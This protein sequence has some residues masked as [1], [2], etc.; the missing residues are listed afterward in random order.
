MTSP[1]SDWAVEGR[2]AGLA[3]LTVDSGTAQH[4]MLHGGEMRQTYSVFLGELGSGVH[5]LSVERNDVYSAKG[6]GVRVHGA[7]FREVAR[8]DPMWPVVAHAPVL[9]AR[10]NTVGH[11]SDVPL[12]AYCERLVENGRPVLQYTVV[13]SNEDGGT[14]TRALM[15]RWGRATD[16]EYVYR[17]FL[18]DGRA[19]IQARDHKEVE[20]R[21]Q[22]D[23]GH[24]LLI[25]STQNNMVSDEGH[26][27]I[28]YQLAPVLVD[29][30]RQARE[31]VMDNA[32]LAYRV[33]AQE[34][35]REAKLR[36]FGMVDGEKISDPRN[37]LYLEA[38][39]TNRNSAV[40]VLARLEGED[41]WRSSHLGRA[42]YAI[43]RDG[44][45]RT[46]IEL[47]L[48]SR[49]QIAELAFECLAV[50][51]KPQSDSGVCRVE[52][53]SKAFLL[54]GDYTPGESIWSLP[55]AVAIPSGQVR[56]FRLGSRDVS[57]PTAP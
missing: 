18:D 53:V 39:V 22:R 56:A 5:Q 10:A 42:S 30:S 13:F 32:P 41:T 49:E 14:S 25:P 20:F 19:T 38:K 43:S 9:F 57:R 6:S 29:L 2:E 3:T 15:A 34:L 26:S 31:Q 35:A 36:P 23:G 33:M 17:Q 52:A 12:L 47:P 21:G 4:V 37:Y 46:T 48:I 1:G 8:G 40:A 24:P 27:P 51:Q 50:E 11:F 54:G 45:V 44:W 16:I 7:R 28:R 55:R